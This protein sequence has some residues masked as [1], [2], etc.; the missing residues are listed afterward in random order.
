MNFGP[1]SELERRTSVLTFTPFI[2]MQYLSSKFNKNI[3]DKMAD[4]SR[5]TTCLQYIINSSLFDKLKGGNN[6]STGIY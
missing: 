2:Y 1:T 3:Y 6:P 4:F 5:S